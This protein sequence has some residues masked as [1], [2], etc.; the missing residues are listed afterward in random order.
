MKY[1][2]EKPAAPVPQEQPAASAPSSAKREVQMNAQDKA[3]LERRSA[4]PGAKAVAPSPMPEQAAPAADAA[5]HSVAKE[6]ASPEM[7]KAKDVLSADKE[8]EAR[9]A[10]TEHFVNFDLPAR[11]KVKGLSFAI[12]RFETDDT[13]L[14][15]MQKTTAYQSRPCTSKYVV[16]VE[17]SGSLSKY[18]YCYDRSKVKLLGVF[19]FK[20]GNWSEIK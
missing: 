7:R 12:R 17:I 5:Q 8:A 1:E 10:V 6:S 2:Y 4:S 13:D 9:L 19:E 20:N 3:Y 16:D 15:W 18:L 11:K 14:P